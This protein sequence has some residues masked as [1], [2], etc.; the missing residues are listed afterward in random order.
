MLTDSITYSPEA[1]ALSA[2]V[3]YRTRVE[4]TNSPEM[5]SSERIAAWCE[6]L[7]T[8]DHDAFEALFRELYDPLLNYALHLTKNRPSALDITQEAFVKLWDKRETLDPKRSIKALLYLIVRNL[9]FNRQRDRMNRQE[10]LAEQAI[11]LQP[12]AP[13]PDEQFEAG[14]LQKKLDAWIEALPD[15]QREALVLSRGQ[16]LSHEEI[17]AVM[18]VSPRTVNNHIVRALK[19]LHSQI[20]SYEPSLLE[21]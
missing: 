15:R 16:G 17:A 4:E 9:A 18:D 2:T 12:G 19:N 13:G 10:K 7:R 1:V 8:S 20:T 6:R 11:R 21:S 14:L 3:S 5:S